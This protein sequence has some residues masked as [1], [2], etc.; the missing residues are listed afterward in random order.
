MSPCRSNSPAR[1]DALA[2]AERELAAVGLAARRHHYPAELS[3]GEQQRVALARA[4]APNPAIVVADEPT[5]NLDEDDRTR[6]HRASVPRPSASAAR[7]SSWSPMTPRSPR[8][9]IGCCACI[10]DSSPHWP[11]S[12]ASAIA[13]TQTARVPL[14][15]K[16]A[17]TAF[18]AVL[19]PVYWHYYG[20]TNFLYFCDIALLLIL[21]AIWPK[22]ALL[23]S[24]CCVGI[25]VPQ[26]VWV[27]DFLLNLAGYSLTGMTDYMF[28]CE[29]FAVPAAAVAVPRLAAVPARLSGLEDSAMTGA[30]S[31]LDRAVL[32]RH[33]DLFL[34]DAAA[35]AAS[36][37]DAG[38]HQLCVGPARHRGADLAAALRLVCRIVARIPVFVFAPTHF[39]LA[40]VMPK[41][42]LMLAPAAK[43][44]PLTP[45]RFACVSLRALPG[46]I[47]AAVC[48]ASAFSSP[49]SRLASWRLPASARSP[50][51]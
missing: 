15:V 47:C 49:V 5:G 7:R 8:A 4:L 9:A 1:A 6:Y 33:A 36:G 44:I 48:A 35:H 31:G 10:R 50:R 18:M 14:G 42:T 13:M 3:G 12:A 32:G 29:P 37:T 30:P 25:L 26:A 17:Y 11:R 45:L 22:N 21:V 16:L 19:V 34:P 28:D 2:R 20:P 43:S 51:A 24:M 40:R 39:M 46:A 23:I 38:Q 27:V 41:A